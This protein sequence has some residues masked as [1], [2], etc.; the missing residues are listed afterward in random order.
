MR[1]DIAAIIKEFEI[2]TS[3]YILL[4]V[5]AS[6]CQ[7]AS[8]YNDFNFNKILWVEAIPE[9]A[10]E[11]RNIIKKFPKQ[12]L[13]QA[14]CFSES[15]VEF[16]MYISNNGKESSSIL[17][18][19]RH[20]DVH[21]NVK[22]NVEDN[23]I[24][25]TTIDEVMKKENPEKDVFLV[26]DVQG[27]ELNVLNGGLRTL[28]RTNFVFSEVS[29]INLYKGQA[30]FHKVVS[31]LKTLGFE[32]FSHDVSL[33]SPYGDALF[34]KNLR[35]QMRSKDFCGSFLF[36]ALSMAYYCKLFLFI[37]KVNSKLKYLFS[38][39]NPTNRKNLG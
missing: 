6:T 25:S 37:R 21:P 26:L 22:F 9:I 18:P 29:T 28:S 13:V 31:T 12:E 14:L 30:L 32:L 5:G 7:E 38:R 1:L 27:A 15:G 16:Q 20:L 35:S 8:Y 3:D 39:L 34:V 24:I 23:S 2:S 11:A 19:N 10:D 36:S 33:K 17:K 4:H